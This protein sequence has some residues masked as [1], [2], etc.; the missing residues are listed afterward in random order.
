MTASKVSVKKRSLFLD[1]VK[2]VFFFY[3][4]MGIFSL[5]L[6][7]EPFS[8]K[9]LCNKTV[10]PRNKTTFLKNGKM[11]KNHCRSSALPHTVHSHTHTHTQAWHVQHWKWCHPS[12]NPFWRVSMP[13]TLLPWQQ[14][15]QDNNVV[16]MLTQCDTTVQSLI[17][18]CV[19]VR[20]TTRFLSP[21]T[22]S[23]P[24][25]FLLQLSSV[26]LLFFFLPSGLCVF[27]NV[28]VCVPVRVRQ[29]VCNAFWRIR[30]TKRSLS[31]NG[32]R[33]SSGF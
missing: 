13:V 14:F 31:S 4:V 19:A 22:P 17:V 3:A 25:F 30:F 18:W 1:V 12:L 11:N 5:F 15:P 21:P 16:A 23:F 26:A 33:P 28:S 9:W 20:W 29:L 2:V 7:T 32:E 6:Y 24:S 27:T 8:T 10:F